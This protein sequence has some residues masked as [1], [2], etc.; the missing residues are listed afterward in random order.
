MGC[1]VDP[2]LALYG[3]IG[4]LQEG[5]AEAADEYWDALDVWLR[6]GGFAPDWQPHERR[7]FTKYRKER[8]AG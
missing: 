1:N 6:S 3:F 5:D 7:L 4:A 8:A 2:N